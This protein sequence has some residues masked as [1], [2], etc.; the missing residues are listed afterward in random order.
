MTN[1]AAIELKIVFGEIQPL[2]E[3]KFSLFHTEAIGITLGWQ[4]SSNAH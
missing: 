4:V 2:L 3:I 1:E